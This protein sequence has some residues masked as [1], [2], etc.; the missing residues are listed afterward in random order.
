MPT[1][2]SNHLSTMNQAE[3]ITAIIAITQVIKFYGI[4]SKFLPAIAVGIGILLQYSE[5]P[6]SKG[7]IDGIILGAMTTGSYGVVKGAAQYAIESSA[8]NPNTKITYPT[9]I[10]TDTDNQNLFELKEKINQLE[11]DDYRGV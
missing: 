2:P 10:K 7:V 4:P 8:K 5:D 6:T 1:I 11:P 9:W 3:K